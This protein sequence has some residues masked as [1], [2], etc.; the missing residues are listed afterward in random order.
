VQVTETQAAQLGQLV[1]SVGMAGGVLGGIA[2]DGDTR[3]HALEGTAAGSALA[4]GLG[5][6]LAR[7]DGVP[8]TRWM[9]DSNEAIRAI[10]HIHVTPYAIR[11]GI[12]FAGIGLAGAALGLG[13]LTAMDPSG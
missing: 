10:E 2:S 4:F 7:H 9:V 3:I 11:G 8:M 1:A 6:T 5:A 12:A 13:F